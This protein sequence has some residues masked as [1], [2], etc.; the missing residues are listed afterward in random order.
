MPLD[1]LPFPSAPH[2]PFPS[3][4]FPPSA[5]LSYPPPPPRSSPPR[6]SP[7]PSH[8]P[9]IKDRRSQVVSRA[10]QVLAAVI[11]KADGRSGDVLLVTCFPALLSNLGRPGQQLFKDS[12]RDCLHTVIKASAPRGFPRFVPELLKQGCGAR[13]GDVKAPAFDVLRL[14]LDMWRAEA[15]AG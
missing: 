12:A 9:Q 14:M 5:H 2:S 8:S 3:H 1:H 13:S 6:S 7:P 15:F 4:P 11:V 10:C